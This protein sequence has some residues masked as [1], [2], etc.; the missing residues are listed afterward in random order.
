MDQVNAVIYKPSGVLLEKD[1][2]EYQH[3]VVKSQ[4]DAVMDQANGSLHQPDVAEH[5]SGFVVESGSMMLKRDFHAH[6]SGFVRLQ[7]GNV[8]HIP[9]VMIF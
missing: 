6:P 1:E 4:S 7:P 8:K 3:G 9:G 5:Q 2:L